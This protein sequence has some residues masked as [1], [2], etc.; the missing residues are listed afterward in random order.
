MLSFTVE[1]LVQLQEW[2]VDLVENNRYYHVFLIASAM[3][4]LLI[5]PEMLDA[6]MGRDD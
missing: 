4:L 1:E 2:V 5:L 3:Y 6:L